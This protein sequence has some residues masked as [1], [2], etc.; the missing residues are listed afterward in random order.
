MVK[1]ISQSQRQGEIT[2]LAGKGFQ[3]NF[4]AS[5]ATRTNPAIS[6]TK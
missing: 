1:G 4:L 2:I 6:Q 3:L 5:M